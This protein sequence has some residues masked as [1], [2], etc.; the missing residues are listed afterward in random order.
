MTGLLGLEAFGQELQHV[1]SPLAT[2]RGDAQHTFHEPTARLASRSPS[3][4]STSATARRAATGMATILSE[5]G[6]CL[7]GLFKLLS[8][9]AG[10]AQDLPAE[11][12]MH[13]LAVVHAQRSLRIDF[14]DFPADDPWSE[15]NA[16]DLVAQQV[17]SIPLL[18]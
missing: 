4:R 15:S 13:L 11:Q 5:M 6:H 2:S 16:N 3:R 1:P 8:V 10:I 14:V 7:Y 18:C 12:A 9:A 17:Q